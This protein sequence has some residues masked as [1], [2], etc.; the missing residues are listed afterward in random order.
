MQHPIYRVCSSRVVVPF[1]LRVV[2]DDD[3]EQVI[4]FRPMLAGGVFVPL[5]DLAV[6]NDRWGERKV[7]IKPIGER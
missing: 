6:F 1:A 5:R 3:I 4:E 2:F 7:T